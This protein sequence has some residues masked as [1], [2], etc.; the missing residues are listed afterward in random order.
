MPLQNP[1]FF[2]FFE[3]FT[4]GLCGVFWIIILLHNKNALEFQSK[5]DGHTFSFPGFSGRAKFTV[6][7]ITASRPAPKAAK[8]PETIMTIIITVGMMFSLW[9]PCLHFAWQM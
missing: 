8:Q 7:S 6:P 2:S 4:G 9:Y 1:H 5:R 3:P